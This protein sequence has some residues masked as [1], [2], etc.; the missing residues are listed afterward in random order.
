MLQRLCLACVVIA[1]AAMAMAGTASAHV[2]YDPST[3][4]GC[5]TTG[6]PWAVGTD[7]D[8]FTPP[9]GPFDGAVVA[10]AAPSNICGSK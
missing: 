7:G 10:A 6:N 8:P 9:Y 4:A 5:I 1:L 3:Q 2:P